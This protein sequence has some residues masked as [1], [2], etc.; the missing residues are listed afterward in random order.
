MFIMIIFDYKKKV[1]TKQI[2]VKECNIKLHYSLG[3]ALNRKSGQPVKGGKPCPFRLHNH[4]KLY[5]NFI[6]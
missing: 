6:R 5:K 1:S 3:F 4:V 2:Q